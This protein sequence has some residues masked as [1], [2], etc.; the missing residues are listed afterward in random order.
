MKKPELAKG[1]ALESGLTEAE[2]ADRLD[3]VVN[4]II[5]RLRKGK[6]AP[7]PGLGKFTQQSNGK[8]SFRREGDKHRG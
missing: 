7:L 4:N 2:A 5:A 8:L 3:R 6:P 1:L